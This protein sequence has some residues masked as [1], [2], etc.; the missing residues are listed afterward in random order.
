MLQV[1]AIA[2]PPVRP[3]SRQ[4]SILVS[5]SSA[6]SGAGGVE[7]LAATLL[8]VFAATQAARAASQPAAVG[9]AGMQP[10]PRRSQVGLMH[11]LL[12]APTS[13]QADLDLVHDCP[14][15]ISLGAASASGHS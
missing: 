5:S 8:E 15:A 12:Q 9:E 6:S 11:S 10:G 2:P 7:D 3:V 4:T 1:E 13:Q 14:E